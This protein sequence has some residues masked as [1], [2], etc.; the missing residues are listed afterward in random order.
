M[1]QSRDGKNLSRKCF[2]LMIN[3]FQVFND[4]KFVRRESQRTSRIWYT[5][6]WSALI[7]IICWIRDVFYVCCCF[8]A[9]TLH[10]RKNAADF[11]GSRMFIEFYANASAVWTFLRVLLRHRMFTI[12]FY[13]N[14]ANW[15][16]QSCIRCCVCF[17]GCRRKEAKPSKVNFQ[18]AICNSKDSNECMTRKLMAWH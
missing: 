11:R 5:G 6:R 16:C 15:H 8:P 18:F 7:C 17:M 4:E 2:R 3:S 1:S 14:C 10:H 13:A 12:I 9:G